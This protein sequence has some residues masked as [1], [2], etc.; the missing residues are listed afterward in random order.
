MHAFTNADNVLPSRCHIYGNSMR[1]ARWCG[2]GRLRASLRR[3]IAWF[4]SLGVEL[5]RSGWRPDRCRNGSM[6]RYAP[7]QKAGLAVELV[8]TRPA[9]NAFKPA[10]LVAAGTLL[11]LL[12]FECRVAIVL[13][14]AG[15]GIG[16]IACGTF[17]VA[18]FGPRRYPQL[19]G[20]LGLP[21]IVAMAVALFAGARVFRL[22]GA[23]WTLGMLA[24]LAT[25]NVL[26]VILFWHDSRVVWGSRR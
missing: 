3:L 21:I 22:G 10:T 5:R 1:P 17:P 23:D 11:F 25:F 19:M 18:L 12:H 7:I 16:S 6:Q 9:R 2:K 26:L 14:A 24:S 15:N 20:R 8:E 4:R 13:S